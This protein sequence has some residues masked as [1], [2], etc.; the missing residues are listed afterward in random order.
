MTNVGYRPTFGE[1]S[2]GVETHLLEPWSGAEPA[3]LDVSFLYWLRRER[4]F[5]SAEQLKEQI[6]SDVRRAQT[7]FRR[8][9]SA[10]ISLT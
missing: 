1:R 4:K 8:L 5:D 6:L 3:L 7:Y 10:G 2:L 9:R